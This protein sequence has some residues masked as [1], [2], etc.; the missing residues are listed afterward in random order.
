MRLNKVVV[1][2]ITLL[3]I[4]LSSLNG[5]N[6]VMSQ[7]ADTDW[8]MFGHNLKHTWRSPYNGPQKPQVKWRFPLE[9]GWRAAPAI[10]GDGTIYIGSRDKNLYA[11]NPNGVLRWKFLAGGGITSSPAIDRDGTIY[12]GSEDN[13]LYAINPSG[14]LKWKFPTSGDVESSPAIG[15]DGTIYVGSDDSFFYAIKPDGTLRWKESN[16]DRVES[17]PAI[18]TDGTIYFCSQD[19]GRAFKAMNPSGTEKWSR[20][21][22]G[23]GITYSSPA[24]AED[25]TIYIGSTDKKLYALNQNGGSPVIPVVSPIDCGFRIRAVDMD[26]I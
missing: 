19:E 4:V 3:F 13:S 15:S 5:F 9:T 20:G 22:S 16:F 8:P 7:Q 6:R 25:G 10:G 24:I 11:I 1:Y 21:I 12:V 14:T 23:W 26:H 2:G 18:A 17:S